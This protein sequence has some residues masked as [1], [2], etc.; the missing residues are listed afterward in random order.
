MP[1]S[2]KG[3]LFSIL[4]VVAT[5]L[6]DAQGPLRIALIKLVVF[7]I[8]TGRVQDQM[9][10]VVKFF[11]ALAGSDQALFP[12]LTALASPQT[13]YTGFAQFAL[14]VVTK[15]GLQLSSEGQNEEHNRHVL[16]LL[17]SLLSSGQLDSLLRPSTPNPTTARFVR[18][19]AK[20]V[21]SVLE[22]FAAENAPY[23]SVRETLLPAAR[24]ASVLVNSN[25]ALVVALDT[26]VARAITA[27]MSSGS[28]I[29]CLSS[30]RQLLTSSTSALR[31]LS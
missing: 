16:S 3:K 23:A 20:Y 21:Q 29:S 10:S 7:L 22:G 28:L 9:S 26:L 27:G 15:R 13:E 8:P 11:D 4:S 2:I 25:A 31:G 18:S 14:P 17:A 30:R 6:V 24:L 1:D 5:K 19:V 12:V